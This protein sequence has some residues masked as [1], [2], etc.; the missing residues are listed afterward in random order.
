[1]PGFGP[2]PLVEL[3]EVA[4]LVGARTVHVK[5][6]AERLGLPSFKVV[7]A[8]WAVNCAIAD[9]L[10]TDVPHLFA[11]TVALADRLPE[12]TA[13]TTATDG[14]HGRAIA[15]I[16]RLVGR[17]SRIFVPSGMAPSRIT[18]IKSEGAELVVVDGSYDD[19]VRRSAGEAMCHPEHLLVSDTSWP[20]YETIPAAVV[21]GYGTIFREAR[22]Q[23]GA[24]GIDVAFIPA[25]V[26]SFAS[27]AV[28]SLCSSAVVTVEPVDADC[29]RRSLVAGEPVTVPGPHRSIMAG[30]NCG[31]V[32]RIAWPV[33]HRGVRT[34]V[35]VTDGEVRNAM[36]LLEAHGIPSGES[37]AAS[38][39]GAIVVGTEQAEFLADRTVL[40]LDTEGVTDPDAY[41]QMVGPTEHEMV[42]PAESP[43]AVS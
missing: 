26:G 7:G 30:L 16:A 6:E 22:A 27:S 38:L 42:R 32:S 21:D 29:I 40:L 20:G 9:R 14:N 15:H 13:L 39:A 23:L 18:A 24:T 33:L 43:T 19:A 17:P 37:G 36:R 31:E 28:Q 25:G 3:P 10:G 1:M 35:T 4:A 8:S 12:G 34:A 5:Y 41:A 11:D 2:T